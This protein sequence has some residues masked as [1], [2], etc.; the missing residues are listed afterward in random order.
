MDYLRGGRG[1][2]APY[3]T[4]HV[5][6]PEPIKQLVQEAAQY[7]R[8]TCCIPTLNV[9]TALDEVD[10]DEVVADETSDARYLETIQ[11]QAQTIQA[12]LSEI[13]YLKQ[14]M[15]KA[16]TLPTLDDAL[17]LADSIAKQK[18]SAAISVTRLV[19]ALYGVDVVSDHIK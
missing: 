1:N 7:Y 16:D 11:S 6:I 19:Y 15:G 9:V 5:R 10:D 12:Y 2:Q 17:K 18:K 14:K 13:N 8:E 4:T 3:T